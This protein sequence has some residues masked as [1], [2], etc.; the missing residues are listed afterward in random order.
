M[1]ALE[2]EDAMRLLGG[3]HPRLMLAGM[4]ALAI[5]SLLLAAGALVLVSG[6][7]RA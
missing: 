5:S 2:L 3:P 1:S 4:A 7:A 6:L